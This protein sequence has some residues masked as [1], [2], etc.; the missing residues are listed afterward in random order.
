MVTRLRPYHGKLHPQDPTT[1]QPE[2]QV[3]PLLLFEKIREGI[4]GSPMVTPRSWGYVVYYCDIAAETGG[5]G[6]SLFFYLYD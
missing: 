2:G 1:G 6:L 4:G 5:S 3:V